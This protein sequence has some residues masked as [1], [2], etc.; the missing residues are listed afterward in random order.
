MLLA[1]LGHDVIVVDQ[2]SFPSDTVSTHAIAR[3]GVVQL[4]RCGLL[5]AV[6]DSGAPAV[7]QV[8]FH[9]GGESVSRAIKHKAGVD[10]VV[11]PRRYML[12]TI[13]GGGRAAGRR[14]RA[15]R[16]HRDRR[17]ARQPRPGHRD[18]RA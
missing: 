16:R 11:A 5:D 2:A 14:R 18:L 4:Q 1:R 13:V 17:A 7:R 9:V 8:T 12:D 10:L 3:S 6:L 15:P